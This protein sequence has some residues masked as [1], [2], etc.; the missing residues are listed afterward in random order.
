MEIRK[1]MKISQKQIPSEIKNCPI[2]GY[3]LSFF[4]GR[5]LTEGFLVNFFFFFKKNGRPLFH[6]RKKWPY[7]CGRQQNKK[8]K[9]ILKKSKKKKKHLRAKQKEG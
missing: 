6:F 3:M 8:Q 9:K 7:F 4:S 5:G 2:F 1:K